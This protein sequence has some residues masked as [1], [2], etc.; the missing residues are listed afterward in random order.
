MGGW[1]GIVG[2]GG[3][4]EVRGKGVEWVR[5]EGR[6]WGWRWGLM[7]GGDVVIMKAGRAC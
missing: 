3:G 1:V 6:S 5:R 2:V 7:W 4:W